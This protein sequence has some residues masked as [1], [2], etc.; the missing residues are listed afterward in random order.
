MNGHSNSMDTKL[1]NCFANSV[2][3]AHGAKQNKTKIGIGTDKMLVFI[4]LFHLFTSLFTLTIVFLSI[5]NP[6]KVLP[7]C[8]YTHFKLFQLFFAM[9][10]EMMEW[11][12]VT[13]AFSWPAYL[14]V[15]GLLSLCCG[16]QLLWEYHFLSLSYVGL[17]LFVY[18]EIAWTN[19]RG[20]LVLL[21]LS[22]LSESWELLFP[23]GWLIFTLIFLITTPFASRSPK[24][25]EDEEVIRAPPITKDRHNL[26]M[27]LGIHDFFLVIYA[28]TGLILS[29]AVGIW[30]II[31]P[32]LFLEL[33]NSFPS[34]PF[35]LH[36]QLQVLNGIGSIVVGL[37]CV[38][39]YFK[40]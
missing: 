34:T 4:Q 40:P 16:N 31:A 38:R 9:Q 26:V 19:A 21:L 32:I 22:L 2:G 23:V 6:V 39:R 20:V 35:P 14:S 37:G 17:T 25:S 8:S 33:F 28:V 30:S 3:V 13:S 24:K 7:F 36:T 27:S 15:Y 18:L 5:L 29:T 10:P 11:H 12:L 1:R